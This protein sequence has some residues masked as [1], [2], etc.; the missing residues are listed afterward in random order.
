MMPFRVAGLLDKKTSTGGKRAA[1]AYYPTKKYHK[2]QQLTYISK[3][4]GKS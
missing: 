4:I 3:S 1:L 2:V